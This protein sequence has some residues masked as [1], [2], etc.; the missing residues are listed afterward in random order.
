MDNSLFYLIYKSQETSKMSIAQIEKL[1]NE[2]AK[3]KIPYLI[4][5]DY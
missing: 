1:T 3:K 4:L 5:L 2:A